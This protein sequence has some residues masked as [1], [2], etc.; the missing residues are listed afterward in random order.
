MYSVGSCAVFE[1]DFVLARFVP[2]DEH[3]GRDARHGRLAE[4]GA[5]L[6][7]ELAQLLPDFLNR[8]DRVAGLLGDQRQA[9][10]L[11]V[12]Q[13]VRRSASAALRSTACPGVS[14]SSR[15]SLSDAGA[16]RPA[17]RAAAR[18]ASACSASSSCSARMRAASPLS[19]R[20]R[21]QQVFQRRLQIAV[22]VEVVDDPVGHLPRRRRRDRTSRAD[23]PGSRAATRAGRP[24]WPS[25][26]AGG[27]L[28]AS[29]RFMR[30]PATLFVVVGQILG[31]V[32]QALEVV[33]VVRCR[34]DDQLALGVGRRVGCSRPRPR[35]AFGDLVLVGSI[36]SRHGLSSI[37]CSMR[38]CRAMIGNCRI[39]I[40]WIIRGASTCF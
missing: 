11:E 16:A 20:D 36:W 22:R 27:R 23:G 1:P 9:I 10:V 30:R 4:I 7:L 8:L 12:F 19:R 24:C 34:L 15:H 37:S 25:R 38:S 40:D 26:R 28:R 2:L 13:V 33:L 21:R 5:R 3:V 17:D 32:Q 29:M 39:S 31:H 35:L 14:C 18:R 6:G